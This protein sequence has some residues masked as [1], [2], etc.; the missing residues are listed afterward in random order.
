MFR[1]LAVAICCIVVTGKEADGRTKSQKVICISPHHI[2]RLIS[3]LGFPHKLLHCCSGGAI[4][5]MCGSP[6]FGYKVNDHVTCTQI[7]SDQ[8]ISWAKHDCVSLLDLFYK[9]VYLHGG[10][11]K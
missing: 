8:R 10:E 3:G 6:C 4:S 9:P 5:K 1:T 7:S 2:K 11:A